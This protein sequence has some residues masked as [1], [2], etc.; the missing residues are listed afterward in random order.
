MAALFARTYKCLGVLAGAAG[1]T[2]A[3]VTT[4]FFV[5][6]LQRIE[7]DPAARAALTAA[8][9]LMV[10][11][12][13]LAFAVAGLL[14]GPQLRGLRRTLIALGAALLVFEAGTMY[15]TQAQ[16][17]ESAQAVRLAQRTQIDILS[18]SI[19]SQ[20]DTL[21]A[22]RDNANLQTQS[23][24]AWIR[25]DGAKTL[26]AAVAAE[27]AIDRQ[28]AELATLQA[29]QRPTMVDV[30]GERGMILYS[31][32][33]S[34][35]IAV[36]GAVMCGAA[37]T[38]WRFSRATNADTQAVAVAPAAAGQA[39]AATP[40]TMHGSYPVV[41]MAG[42]FRGIAVPANT[43]RIRP[44]QIETATRLQVAATS[45][46]APEGR[47]EPETAAEVRPAR[48][49]RFERV[50]A[51]IR[52][53]EI[54]PSVRAVAEFCAAGQRVATRYLRELEAAGEIRKE[55]TFYVRA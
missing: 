9:M 25:E 35:L 11:C 48:D 3:A 28:A 19:K 38:L 26:R 20:R 29:A 41:A 7:P 4:Q 8:G 23:R 45:V 24:Y 15:L 21:A 42:A 53:G 2:A 39:P 27:P 16:L 32:A 12:E 51:A 22:M 40:K 49:T 17:A 14:S 10:G 31:A 13:M 1:L 47:G 34:L 46:P 50:R 44:F 6:S 5:F 33:R 52:S 30:L 36:M 54:R 37:G 55:G 18:G 43:V